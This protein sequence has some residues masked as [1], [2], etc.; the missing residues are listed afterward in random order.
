MSFF[1]VKFPGDMGRLR[2]LPQLVLPTIP[3]EFKCPV[4]MFVV[5]VW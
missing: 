1:D 3:N 5:Y 2:P 4:E